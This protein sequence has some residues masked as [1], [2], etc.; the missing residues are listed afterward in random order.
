MTSKHNLEAST[1]YLAPFSHLYDHGPLTSISAETN[2]RTRDICSLEWSYDINRKLEWIG[3]GALK[4]HRED[5]GLTP[6]ISSHTYLVIQRLNYRFWGNFDLGT[7]YRSLIQTE[8]EDQRSGWL[9]EFMW[10]IVDHARLGLGYNFTDFSD[11]EF[12]DNDY[13]VQG[14]FVRMQAKY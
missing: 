7:E 9:A 10:Q 4:I 5:S 8:A 6:E 13:S 3:K 14:W 11:N 12:S 2:K 1:I